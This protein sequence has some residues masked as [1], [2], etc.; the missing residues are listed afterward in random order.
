[1]IT[2]S[3]GMR[4]AYWGKIDVRGK[5]TIRVVMADAPG[6]GPYF[7]PTILIGSPGQRIRIEVV[8][9]TAEGHPFNLPAQGINAAVDPG[10]KR[11]VTVQ[12]PASGAVTFSC[13][14]TGHA[15]ELRTA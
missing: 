15:G 2:L 12:F 11:Q 13:P 5:T 1:M 6:G 14:H 4:A 9:K 7:S 3:D 8:N 10:G